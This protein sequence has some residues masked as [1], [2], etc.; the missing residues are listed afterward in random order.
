[1]GVGSKGEER[2]RDGGTCLH[3][4]EDADQKYVS[5][6]KPNQTQSTLKAKAKTKRP[7]SMLLFGR[8]QKESGSLIS[9]GAERGT[10]TFVHT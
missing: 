9:F 5:V 7:W 8:F 2:T 1:M 3:G 10:F 4:K 6:W